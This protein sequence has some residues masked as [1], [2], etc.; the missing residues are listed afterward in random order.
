MITPEQIEQGPNLVIIVFF[1]VMTLL[2][3]ILI[4]R[5][6][7]VASDTAANTAM[8]VVALPQEVEQPVAVVEVAPP[9]QEVAT[10]APEPQ[11]E[12]IE[13]P[14]NKHDEIV[15]SADAL[16]LPQQKTVDVGNVGNLL[17]DLSKV[18]RKAAN[19]LRAEARKD[20]PN[21]E[22][23]GTWLNQF[24]TYTRQLGYENKSP[25]EL[26]ALIRENEPKPTAPPEQTP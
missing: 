7:V 16:E 11:P 23:V 5:W 22:R 13:N 14:S 3:L 8:G 20:E 21:T 18:N 24:G 26:F 15:A 19:D 2:V 6:T 17:D 9:I 10:P 12:A 1:A 4:F 25:E